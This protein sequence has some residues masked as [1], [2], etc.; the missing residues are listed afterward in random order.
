MTDASNRPLPVQR[1]DPHP[2][3]VRE[4]AFVCW[5]QAD[6][7]AARALRLLEEQ[8][9]E[10]DAHGRVP[11]A[12]VSV[13]AGAAGLPCRPSFPSACL[14]RVSSPSPITSRSVTHFPQH[15]NEDI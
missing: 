11:T 4:L 3:W 7:N 10:E 2:E 8:W 9:P 6:R 14:S 1:Q 12:F 15:E 13:S 5:V